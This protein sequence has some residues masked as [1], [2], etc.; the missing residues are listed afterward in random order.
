MS[1]KEKYA[2]VKWV[3]AAREGVDTTGAGEAPV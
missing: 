3:E 2:E 1:R